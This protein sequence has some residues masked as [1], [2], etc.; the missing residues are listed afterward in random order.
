MTRKNKYS[1]ENNVEFSS[2]KKL[3]NLKRNDEAREKNFDVFDSKKRS[4]IMSKVKSVNNRSTELRL[5]EVFKNLGLVGWRRQAK[6]FGKPDFVFPKLRIIVFVDGCFWHGHKCRNT[7]PKDHAEYWRAKIERNQARD[8]TVTEHLT[9]LGYKVIRIWECEF[10]KINAD[11]LTE[12]LRPI[13]D[14]AKIFK[15]SCSKE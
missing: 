4:E 12:K 10:K 2:D 6:L 15:E 5:V 8:R 1:L 3:Q 11:K 14:A 7:T 13:V 9:K